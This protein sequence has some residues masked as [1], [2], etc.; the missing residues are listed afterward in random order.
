M[1]RVPLN[2]AL[3]KLG[4]LSRSEATDAVLAGRV[5]VSGRVVRKPTTLVVLEGL[6]VSIDEATRAQAAW[7]TIVF[8]KPRGVVTTKRDPE[9]RKTVFDVLG[10]AAEKL[11]PVGRLDLA[12]SG[13][14]LLTNDTD[15]ANR[16][17]DPASEV[18]RVYLVTVR[19]RVTPGA[20][21]ALTRGDGE[22]TMK[23]HSIEIRKT[24]GR[25]SHLT[26]EL[27]QGRNREVR[28]LMLAAGHEVTRLKRVRFG[29]LELGSLGP[30]EWREVSRDEI[31]AA[32]PASAAP[33]L[34]ATSREAGNPG[35]PT[36]PRT[37]Q[38]RKT[39]LPSPRKSRR[40]RR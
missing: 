18:P 24:S 2:R 30:A 3:S 16:I 35:G 26:V 31:E 8:H 21:A 40:F 22:A 4:L 12:S 34:R 10:A 33:T 20:M 15:L 17:S 7:R 13:L 9:G 25:E 27:R 28:R 29:G 38:P 11:N 1:H 39:S 36:P 23:A 37:A 32:F 5:R 6:D 14:L 19:G